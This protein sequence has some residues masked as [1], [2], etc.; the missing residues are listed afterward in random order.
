L[1][2]FTLIDIGR[3]YKNVLLHSGENMKNKLA[4]MLFVIASFI[5]LAHTRLEAVSAVPSQLCIGV[6]IGATNTTI[7]STNTLSTALDGDIGTSGTDEQLIGFVE[8]NVTKNLPTSASF[9]ITQNEPQPD[10]LPANSNW[11]LF[12]IGQTPTISPTDTLIKWVA[13]KLYS[14]VDATNTGSSFVYIPAAAVANSSG[15]ATL[16]LTTGS[17]YTMYNQIGIL[18]CYAVDDA[19]NS[20]A[21]GTYEGTFLFGFE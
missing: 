12:L 6:L 9:K 10:T 1:L 18:S 5:G 11:P 2:N 14:N 16:K 13:M 7:L 20:A 19:N 21:S 3:I 15:T 8:F 17:T 4:M